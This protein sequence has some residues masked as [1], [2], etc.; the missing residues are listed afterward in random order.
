MP[1]FSAEQI[2]NGVNG[3][4]HIQRDPIGGQGSGLSLIGN[5]T[6]VIANLNVERRAIAIPGKYNRSHKRMG[7]TGEGSLMMYRVNTMAWDSMRDSAN[8][9]T[10]QPIFELAMGLNDAD[11]AYT[12]GVTDG[13]TEEIIILKKVKFWVWNWGFNVEELVDQTLEFTF[14]GAELKKELGVRSFDNPGF[15]IPKNP[16]TIR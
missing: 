1:E 3:S 14:E 11:S 9:N 12:D 13:D 10:R 4:L 15:T 5:A 7:W 2:I 8:H 6:N 16:I